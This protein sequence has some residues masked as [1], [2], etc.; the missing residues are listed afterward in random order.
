MAVVRRC[1]LARSVAL[2]GEARRRFREG[3]R[4]YGSCWRQLKQQRP[5][6]PSKSAGR[7]PCQWLYCTGY[8]VAIPKV[9]YK[10]RPQD[11]DGS[12]VP[13]R[14]AGCCDCLDASLSVHAP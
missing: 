13:E 7:V 8:T 6:Y 12:G 5:L 3:P 4:T 2:F 14:D 10:C 11:V 9:G 1:A